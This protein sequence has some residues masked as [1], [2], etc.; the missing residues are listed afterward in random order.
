MS[1]LKIPFRSFPRRK[2]RNL[3]TALAVA[4]SVSLFIGVNLAT[5]SAFEAF[6][7]YLERGWGETDLILTYG[8]PSPFDQDNL[9]LLKGVEG[10][11]EMAR[12]LH[13]AAF[14]EGNQEEVVEARGVDP[15]EYYYT[16]LLETIS[17]GGELKGENV[18]ITKALAENYG[19]GIG[20]WFP[21]SFVKSLAENGTLHYLR[22][23][24][25]YEP[26][27]R[28]EFN[29][30]YFFIRLEEL[31]ELSGMEGKLS[32]LWIKLE[33][34]EDTKKVRDELE[35]V[36]GQEFEIHAP[37]IEA[38]EVMKRQTAS[39]RQGLDAMVVVSLVVCLFLVFNTM[40]ITVRERISEI[41]IL[42]SVG[43]SSP[44]IFSV[45]FAES[46]LLGIL[47]VS[48][49]ILLGLLLG[50]GF[51]FLFVGVEGM[52]KE[53]YFT[54][55]LKTLL[56]GILAGML[57]VLGGAFYPS[58]AACRV[59]VD[60]ALRP[61]MRGEGVKRGRL[62]L[63]GLSLFSLGSSL[64]LGLLP[65]PTP[66]LNFF[67]MAVGAIILAALL[68][69]FLSLHL[70][71]F[72]GVGR[73]VSKNL[74]RKI[75]R[76]AVCFGIVGM[77]LSFVVMLGGLKT[78]IREAMEESVKESLG[79]DLILISEK[80]LPVEFVENL[81]GIE[82]VKEAVPVSI[83]YPGT[84]C[85]EPSSRSMGVF[86]V[87]P[88]LLPKVIRQDF[89]DPPG[90]PPEEAYLQLSQDP[91][92]LLLPKHLAEKL[93]VRAGD[94]LTLETW[95]L[96]ERGMVPGKENFRVVG[97]FTGA[98]LEHVWIGSH[99]LSESAVIG[100]LTQDEYFY[101]VWG[102]GRAWGFL[103]NVKEG[104][105]PSEI[106]ERI[107]REYPNYGFSTHSITQEEILEYARG[108]IDRVFNI[109]FAVLYFSVLIGAIAIAVV[110][111]MNVT[112]RRR[113]IG[114]LRSQGMSGSQ[115]LLMFLGEAVAVGLVGLV[116]G[117]ICGP[118]LLKGVTSSM[119]FAGF[120]VEMVL[121]LQA[122]LHASL[123]AFVAAISGGLYPSYK[124]SKLTIVEAL[125]R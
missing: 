102:K 78:G 32:S 110:M 22:V 86:V 49:G 117:L 74:G 73:L 67:I 55:S 85:L 93:G 12:V 111:L 116:I 96:T 26:K 94:H 30:K 84:K 70:S 28:V 51:L 23:S 64:Q 82:G 31:Q 35:E 10:I 20:D 103:V 62:L 79:A 4:V 56:Q 29:Q 122:I 24:G 99:P 109:L 123:L 81:R 17:G 34:V 21:V 19:L 33:R 71:G 61:E 15:S 68:L 5:G 52:G 114:I 89:V 112:E 57:A 1:L 45:F 9:I 76:T 60:Q 87:D 75:L 6:K 47:G 8:S 25:I 42:R 2:T 121:P 92:T 59:T 108:S 7:E 104:F 101:P 38:I 69:S 46:F 50:R 72:G 95:K 3:L 97:I 125:R 18:V 14:I 98:V 36:F 80:N 44:Q 63:A 119:S 100:F 41:G 40:F 58:L 66:G 48:L 43:A 53:L 11:K 37:K 39:F 118:I 91:K 83:V 65:S 107:D 90:L 16:G 88:Q 105:N 106:R 115:V 113:E 27:E 54:P 13:V 77:S 124:A 120:T